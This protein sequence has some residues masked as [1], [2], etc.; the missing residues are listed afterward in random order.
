[1]FGFLLTVRGRNT[2]SALGRMLIMADGGNASMADGSQTPAR[3]F[4][5]LRAG[6]LLEN[7]LSCRTPG[8]TGRKKAGMGKPDYMKY[9][10]RI[11]EPPYEEKNAPSSCTVESIVGQPVQHMTGDDLRAELRLMRKTIRLIA[12]MAGNPDPA[13]ACRNII[14]ACKHVM[15]NAE[16]EA[17]T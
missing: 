13:K 12:G 15:P 2:Q 4:S 16:S 11:E 3:T 1:M 8:V 10:G 5:Q 17:L 7:V 6:M 9:D 14:S